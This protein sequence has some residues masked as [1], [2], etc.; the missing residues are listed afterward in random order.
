[1]KRR[2]F[3]STTGKTL[4]LATLATGLGGVRVNALTATPALRQLQQ[5]TADSDR[6]FVVVQL[7]GGNDG[8]N[9]VIPIDNATY[10]NSRPN[11]A[12]PKAQALKLRDGLGFHPKMNGF[13]QLF[14]EGKLSIVQNVTYP[15]PDRSHFRGTDIWMTATD[16][17]VFKSTGWMGR[18]LQTLAPNFPDVMPPDPLAVQI[19]TS[20]ALGFR[21]DKGSMGITFRDP[22][23]FYASVDQTNNAGSYDA[24]PDT[25]GG[26]ELDFVRSVEKASQVYSTAVKRAADTVKQNKVTYPTSNPL[27]QSLKIVARLVAGGLKTK[28]YLVNISGTSF[29]THIDQGGVDGYHATLLNYLSEGIKLFMDDCEQLGIG[30]RVAGITFSEFGRRVSENGSRGTDHGTAAPLFAFGKNVIGGKI[31]GHDPDLTKLDNRGDI[32]IEYDYRQ[33]YA[34][35]LLQW[36]GVPTTD[37]QSILFREFSALPLFK[38]IAAG[39]DD[40]N[41]VLSA[42]MYN[43]PN[44]CNDI[45]VINYLVPQASDVTVSLHDIRGEK[46]SVLY[47]GAQEMGMHSV[48]ARTSS[49]AAGTY[50]YK[51]RVG[52]FEQMKALNVIR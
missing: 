14:D 20:L 52:R 18:Y 6:V 1:M 22:E 13:K 32:I 33:I 41:T 45:T 44:P 21:A 27:A 48:T 10:Y 17:D 51:V 23:A 46:I 12:I 36:F 29:D 37:T 5:I 47:S 8:L 38:Q 19:G 11:L 42:S 31:H 50:F 3:I 34:A 49:L 7:T 9:T 15:N 2:D 4:T 25:A 43:A 39:V 40:N 35:S 28:F 30:E 24:A 16:V 26:D